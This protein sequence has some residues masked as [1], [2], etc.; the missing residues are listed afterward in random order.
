MF[1]IFC[2][3]FDFV[4]LIIVVVIIFGYLVDG[5]GFFFEKFIDGGDFVVNRSVDVIGVF[6]RFDCIDGIVLVDLV[7][8]FGKF[9]VDDVI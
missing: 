5:G 4:D 6:D 8:V 7:V 2:I 9:N 1:G 3:D